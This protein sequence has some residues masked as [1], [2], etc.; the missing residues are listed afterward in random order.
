MFS[1]T[2]L[3]P[4]RDQP[5]PAVACSKAISSAVCGSVSARGRT[6]I[7][8]SDPGGRP[9]R[10]ARL[11]ASGV[12]SSSRITASDSTWRSRSALARERSRCS[13]TVRAPS[14]SARRAAP[15]SVRGVLTHTEPSCSR[16]TRTATTI[17]PRIPDSSSAGMKNGSS[18]AI[19]RAYTPRS[20]NRRRS[21]SGARRPRMVWVRT[22]SA[23]TCPRE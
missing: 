18:P 23:S 5:K 2:A 9:R 14:A 11:A 8:C 16:P 10:L 3:R 6:A 21:D 15:R 1:T 7:T 13:A 12:P 20:T 22:G 17:R 4:G 19:N